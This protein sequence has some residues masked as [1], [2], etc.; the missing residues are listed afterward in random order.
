MLA[1]ILL[2]STVLGGFYV[3]GRILWR[4]LRLMADEPKRKEV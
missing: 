4:A 3:S 1:Q 2:L